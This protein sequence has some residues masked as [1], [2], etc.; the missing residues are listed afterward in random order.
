MK[1]RKVL[2]LL[3]WYLKKK[4]ESSNQGQNAMNFQHVWL[5]D[6]R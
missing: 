4:G 1:T 2:A 3:P 5:S 6:H